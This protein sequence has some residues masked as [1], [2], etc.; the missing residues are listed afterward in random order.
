MGTFLPLY[1][2]LSLADQIVVAGFVDDVH[3]LGYLLLLALQGH[4][5]YTLF[6]L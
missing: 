5:S 3:D 1:D 4:Q 2:V 6:L